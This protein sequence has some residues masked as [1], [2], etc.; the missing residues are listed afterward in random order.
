[1]E[2]IL[3]SSNQHKLRE[4][5]EILPPGYTIKSLS[6]IGFT[7]TIEENAETIRG[8]SLLKALAVKEFLNKKG[9]TG[10]VLADDSGLEVRALDGRPGVHSARYAG[11]DTNDATNN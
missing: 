4:I 6:D 3:A 1:M 11:A 2:I 10:A 8:N 7:G 9:L 5:R